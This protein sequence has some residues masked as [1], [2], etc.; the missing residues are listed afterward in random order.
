M[1]PGTLWL[2]RSFSQCGSFVQHSAQR[3]SRCSSVYV[4]RAS[5]ARPA[6]GSSTRDLGSD[7]HSAATLHF[8]AARAQG[9]SR[10]DRRSSDRRI[11]EERPKEKQEAGKLR[12]GVNK[13]CSRSPDLSPGFSTLLGR[14]PRSPLPLLDDPSTRDSSNS[15]I[16]PSVG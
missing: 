3:I 14:D 11:F 5:A 9:E 1:T 8:P 6:F 4:E 16:N 13:I 12:R 15:S 2:G 10:A 7:Q